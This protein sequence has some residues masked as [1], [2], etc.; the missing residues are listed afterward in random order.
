MSKFSD[1]LI[2]PYASAVS[3]F[4]RV[5]DACLIVGSFWICSDLYKTNFQQDEWIAVV[6]ALLFFLFFSQAK[7]LYQSWR[8]SSLAGEVGTIMLVWFISLASMIVL[9]FFA[10]TSDQYSRV[11]ITV[12]G[13]LAPALMVI[14]R[15]AVRSWL[16]IARRKGWN[17]RT[18]VFAGACELAEQLA[19]RL[20]NDTSF[21]IKVLGVY[22]EQIPPFPM[23]NDLEYLG[24]LTELVMHAKAGK[25]DYLY[26]TLPYRDEDKVMGLIKQLSDTPAMVYVVPDMFFRDLSYARWLTIDG[27]PIISVFESPFHGADG[28]LKRFEDVVLGILIL[29][30]VFPLLLVIAF[31]VKLTSDGPVLFKQRRYGL[32]GEVI[33]VWKFRTMT[34]LDND[35]N[36]PQATRKD[37]RITRVGGFLRRSSLDELPQFIN[38]LQGKMSIVGPRPHA[39]AHNEQYRE[40][41]DGYMLRHHV[42]PGITGWAQVHGW[43]GETDTL[44]KMRKRVEY[45]LDYIYNWSLWLDLKIVMMTIFK[46]FFNKNAY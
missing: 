31:A 17:S 44:E 8:L 45:D 16:R 35:A 10:K 13:I 5:M 30:L 3:L 1:G 39:V 38:V 23:V 15:V 27:I 41:I 2:R 46:G 25:L 20:K 9:A 26:I 34:S 37:P 29:L 18:L 40:L 43:R 32:R 11:V 22:D 36:I 24:D 33:E 7:G 19:K 4:Q 28:W 6:L 42:K 21:G 12:W 14:L